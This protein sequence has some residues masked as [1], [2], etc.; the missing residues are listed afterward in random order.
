[1]PRDPNPWCGSHLPEKW[2]KSSSCSLGDHFV[3]KEA[4]LKE[5]KW[6]AFDHTTEKW[7]GGLHADS[8]VSPRSVP[9]AQLF[10]QSQSTAPPWI[11]GILLRGLCA[12]ASQLLKSYSWF[13]APSPPL[14]SPLGLC[15]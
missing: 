1:M 14:S 10:H 4:K 5:A 12:K 3:T 6:F 8:S 2:C 7:R 9:A 13:S 11:P 15:L